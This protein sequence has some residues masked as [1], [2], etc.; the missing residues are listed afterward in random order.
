LRAIFR[1]YA[2]VDFP[3]A[4][5]PLYAAIADNIAGDDVVMALASVVRPGQPPPNLLFAAVHELLLSGVEHPLG[6]YYPDV[7]PSPLPRAEAGPHFRDFCLTH[8]E[9]I[10]EL[11]R[12]RLVQTNVLERCGLLLPAI[13]E[14]ASASHELAIIEI[15]ASAGLN[16]L[17]DRYF[18]DYGAITWGDPSSPVSL[19]IELRGSTPLPHI[20]AD[21]RTAWRAGIDINPVDLRDPEAM[22]WQRALMWPERID[23]Q[24]R[25]EA[26]RAIMGEDLPRIIAGDAAVLLPSLLDEVPHELPL[27]VF[28]SFTLYQFTPDS[29]ERVMS[30]IAGHVSATGRPVSLITVDIRRGDAHATIARTWFEHDRRREQTRARGHPHGAWIEWMPAVPV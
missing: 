17:W 30:A 28:A 6:G 20:P 13:A 11:V 3:A 19:L 14:A 10:V 27:V 26:A 8:R 23:R 22:L 5:A 21:L 2:D 4:G 16:L 9:R 7:T 18:Y 29:R 15:G 1:H 25:L 24:R 12:A